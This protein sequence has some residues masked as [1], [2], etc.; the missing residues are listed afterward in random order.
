MANYKAP[1]N[2]WKL[3]LTVLKLIKYFVFGEQN[4]TKVTF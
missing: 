4:S 2:Y 1:A 3:T